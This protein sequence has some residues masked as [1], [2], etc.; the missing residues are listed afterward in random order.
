TGRN[1]GWRA[2]RDSV[3]T[4]VVVARLCIAHLVWMEIS[5][6]H[7]LANRAAIVATDLFAVPQE[8]RRRTA[9]FRSHTI[10]AMYNVGVVLWADCNSAFRHARGTARFKQIRRSLS[11]PRARRHRSITRSDGF[12]AVTMP[13]T[14]EKPSFL[15]H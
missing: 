3:I 12:P 2:H 8:D 15:G 7:Y 6:L 4:L 11:R 5:K 9:I 14:A 10:S 13:S 1:A